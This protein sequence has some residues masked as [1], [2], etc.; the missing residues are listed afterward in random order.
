MADI[1]QTDPRTLSVGVDTGGTFTDL[2]VVGPAAGQLR[3][4]KV[5]TDR[6]RPAET[7]L[8]ALEAVLTR[9]E[10]GGLLRGQ[11][12]VSH[13]STVATNALL[14]RRGGRT[15]L[16]TTR[17]FQDVLALGRGTRSQLYSLHPLPRPVLVEHSLELN[18]RIAADGQVLIGL[19]EA[20]LEPLHQRL[21]ELGVEAIAVCLL[22]SYVNPVHE[23]RVAAFLRERGWPVSVSSEVSPEYREY[24]RASTVAVDAYL[25]APIEAYLGELRR[26]LPG[27]LW[28]V[29]SG[30]SVITPE[31]AAERPVA[32]VLSGPAAGVRGAWHQ[33]G[34]GQLMTFDMGGTSTDV[35]LCPGRI[36][37]VS[38]AELEEFPIRQSMVDVHTVGAGGGSIAWIDPGGALRVGPRSA[39]SIPGPAAYGTSLLPTVTDANLYLGRLPDLL[40]GS[41]PLDR[42]RSRQALEPLA[43][44]L[45]CSVEQVAEAILEVA[46]TLMER[47]LRRISLERG[48]DPGQFTLVPYGGAGTLHACALAERLGIERILVVPKPGLLC[49]WGALCSPWMREFSRTVL[50]QDDH[51]AVFAELEGQA[52]GSTGMDV[53]TERW[54]DLRYR[55]QGSCLTLAHELDFHSEH[56]RNFGYARA[57]FEVEVVTLRV[58]AEAPRQMPLWCATERTAETEDRVSIWWNGAP[59]PSRRLQRSSLSPG[60]LLAGPAQL[61]SDDTT[62]LV[63]PGW[64]AITEE[65]GNLLLKR[66]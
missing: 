47:A 11:G 7:L 26:R 42:Q 54:R 20:Q 14:E 28:V 29:H 60:Q 30:G 25:R 5:P 13:G 58:R 59:L 39:G 61:L 45:G 35:C 65:S 55:G 8:G 27:E 34:G 51:E 16:V 62:V 50:G 38:Q 43:L 12:S 10:F 57:D 2:I 15:A 3:S 64:S 44:S 17:G 32:M 40:A 18:E 41:I 21:R 22:F 9:A 53:R 24:E 19:D 31:E 52:K 36:P 23:R 56:Q 37:L 4:R 46:E 33:T 66:E 49:A 6:S 48:Y 63:A 1:P